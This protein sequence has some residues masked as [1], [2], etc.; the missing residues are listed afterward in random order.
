M[1]I[2][3]HLLGVLLWTSTLFPRNRSIPSEGSILRKKYLFGVFHRP[4]GKKLIG[5][6][7]YS[8]IFLI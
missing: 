5:G 1:D 4:C 6:F 7:L 2:S 8:E 3:P